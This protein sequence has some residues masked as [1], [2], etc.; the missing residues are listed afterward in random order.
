MKKC[1]VHN[2][3]DIVDEDLSIEALKGCYL[4]LGWMAHMAPKGYWFNVNS[5]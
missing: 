5:K 4:A 3:H 1:F 2:I